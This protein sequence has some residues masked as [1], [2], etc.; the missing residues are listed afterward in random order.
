MKKVTLKWKTI[1]PIQ[2]YEIK[3]LMTDKMLG[4]MIINYSHN[5]KNLTIDDDSLLTIDGYHHVALREDPLNR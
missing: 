2:K 4:N 3:Y 5:I 1:F